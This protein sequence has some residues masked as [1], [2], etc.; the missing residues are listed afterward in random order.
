MK[1]NE[2]EWL[3]NE[4][5]ELMKISGAIVKKSSLKK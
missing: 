3:I 1:E 5:F 4:S 2:L